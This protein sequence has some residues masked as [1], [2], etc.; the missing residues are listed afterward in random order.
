MMRIEIFDALKAQTRLSRPDES[1]GT[2]SSDLVFPGAFR[3][4]LFC[5]L[6]VRETADGFLGS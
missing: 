2:S 3:A 4:S 6:A 1:A 5:L